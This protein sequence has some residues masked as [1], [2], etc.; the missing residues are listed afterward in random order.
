M[1]EGVP[2]TTGSALSA[3]MALF[4]FE[5]ALLRVALF[6]EE[7]YD[8]TA[9]IDDAVLA[10]LCPFAAA[11]E[12]SSCDTIAGVRS[13]DGRLAR[14]KVGAAPFLEVLEAIFVFQSYYWPLIFVSAFCVMVDNSKEKGQ[15]AVSRDGYV[16]SPRWSA[17]RRPLVSLYSRYSCGTHVITLL[18]QSC[19]VSSFPA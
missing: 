13:I 8:G 4:L 5:F 7:V 9:G 10:W 15:E 6:L 12:S 1:F 17:L 2:F 3:I 11:L 16:R 14:S 19:D 18:H